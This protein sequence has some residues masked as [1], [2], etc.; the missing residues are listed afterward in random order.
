[1]KLSI[2]PLFLVGFL[3][4]AFPG[5][6]PA[7][8]PAPAALPFPKGDFRWMASQPLVSPTNRPADPCFSIKDPSVVRFDDR[9][10]R[11]PAPV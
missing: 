9:Y 5:V 3:A 2:H 11:A 6:T 8:E 10:G 1:M 7:T 4:F